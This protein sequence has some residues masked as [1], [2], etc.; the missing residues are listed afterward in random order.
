MLELCPH[1]SI[2]PLPGEQLRSLAGSTPERGTGG[3]GPTEQSP[4]CRQ[5]LSIA[6]ILTVVLLTWPLHAADR[7]DDPADRAFT[8]GLD[9]T[10][11]RYV[12][13]RPTNFDPTKPVDIVIAL[14]GHGSDRWQYV[15]ADRGECRGVRDVAARHG[16]IM[17]SPDYRATTSWMGPAA[18]SDLVQLIGL[19]REQY[20]VRRVYLAGASMGGTSVLIFAAL[21]PDLTDGVLSENGTAN[22]LEYDQ[23]QDAIAA[24]YGGSK[25]EQPDEYRRRSPE[26][27]PDKLTMPLAF[28]VGGRDTIVPPV[29]VRRLSRSLK[30]QDRDDVLLIDDFDG[31][32]ATNYDDTVRAFE[33][34]VRQAGL[35][36]EAP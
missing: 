16:M 23:F 24:S 3:E 19:L 36:D 31:G 22:M 5:A 33:F 21:H 9:D 34:V 28:T 17:V 15:R 29:S 1:K 8:A 2:P 35:R 4:A 30:D 18:E 10:I 26:L 12:E 11:Q 27:I 14:H 20:R 6:A 7:F 13:L 25:S 32:H